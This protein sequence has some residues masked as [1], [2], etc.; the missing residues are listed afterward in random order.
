MVII[1]I[2]DGRGQGICIHSH[3]NI[4]IGTAGI[5]I[6]EGGLGIGR[7]HGFIVAAMVEVGRGHRHPAF[8][9]AVL[10][11]ICLQLGLPISQ[12]AVYK[13]AGEQISDRRRKFIIDFSAV[14]RTVV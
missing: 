10:G 13:S 8:M 3:Q 2:G 4:R 9:Q 14:F 1:I 12:E 5:E 6:V 11:K 7:R